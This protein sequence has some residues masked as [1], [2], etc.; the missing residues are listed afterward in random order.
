[1]TT[2]TQ[3]DTI[4]QSLGQHVLS[5]RNEQASPPSSCIMHELHRPTASDVNLCVWLFRD[6]GDCE[7]YC[8][9][10]LLLHFHRLSSR[11]VQSTT[12][13]HTMSSQPATPQAVLE[14]L[15]VHLIPTPVASH[16]PTALQLF[17]HLTLLAEK[18]RNE[19]SY[20]LSLN[21]DGPHANTL[22]G[23]DESILIRCASRESRYMR[24]LSMDLRR[25]V[26]MSTSLCLT[27][28]SSTT[29]DV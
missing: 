18:V 16:L 19:A 28:A 27:V 10:G 12:N 4:A 17:A 11:R 6:G 22:T 3:V 24:R 5:T 29:S 15:K 14:A 13:T 2:R 26:K 7:W 1:M 25:E 21:R 23:A 9:S 20:C 8:I